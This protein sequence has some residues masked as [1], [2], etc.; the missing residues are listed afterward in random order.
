MQEV[1]YSRSDSIWDSD[2]YAL[3]NA[4]R[5]G[6]LQ[7]VKLLIDEGCEFTKDCEW[8]FR[9][10][11][12]GGSYEVVKYLVSEGSNPSAYGEHGL[13]H[14]CEKGDI[15]MVKLLVSYGCDYRCDNDRPLSLAAENGKEEVLDYLLSLGAD[16]RKNNATMQAAANGHLKITK[17]LV[18]LGGDALVFDSEALV[19]ACMQNYFDMVGYL[20]SQGAN[21]HAHNDRP[22]SYAQ[23][24]KSYESIYLLVKAGVSLADTHRTEHHVSEKEKD[25]I[26]RYVA[27]RKKV[28]ERRKTL[29]QEKIYFWWIPICYDITRECGQRMREKNYKQYVEMLA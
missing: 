15:E 7:T 18:S 21:I 17:K 6:E 1:A 12:F 26:E 16:F 14:S 29:A 24:H 10:A 27:F 5:L 2:Y 8:A 20:L 13:K 3:V 25:F 11:V 23:N 4:C 22:N 19:V 28:D 9:N